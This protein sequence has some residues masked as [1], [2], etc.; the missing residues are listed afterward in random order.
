VK[1]NSRLRFSGDGFD[2]FPP[3]KAQD[4]VPSNAQFAETPKFSLKA[5]KPRHILEIDE[6]LAQQASTPARP[7]LVSRPPE[8]IE[9]ASQDDSHDQD[10]MLFE[11]ANQTEEDLSEALPAVKRQRV[12]ELDQKATPRRFVFAPVIPTQT[13]TSQISV[14]ESSIAS[15]RPA[16]R[17]PPQEPIASSEPLPNAFSPHRRGQR[18]VPGGMAAEVQQW[19]VETAQSTGQQRTSNGNMFQASLIT[20]ADGHNAGMT[21]LRVQ[22]EL[23]PLNLLLAGPGK[24]NSSQ[25]LS[26]GD[27][28]GIKPPTWQ[29]KLADEAWVVATD[30]RAMSSEPA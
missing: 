22:S 28:L 8:A 1:Q 11:S 5:S 30:W 21:L 26:Q 23:G 24:T 17:L 13:S 4:E 19:I 12:E 9:D 27:V 20:V 10:E 18:F 29:I 7:R 14:N 25:P 16:F 6:S 2:N 15:I 3:Q